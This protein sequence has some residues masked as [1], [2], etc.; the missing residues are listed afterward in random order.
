MLATAVIALAGSGDREP[1]A[2]MCEC[3]HW[4]RHHSVGKHNGCG[5]C[6]C[7]GFA[8]ARPDTTNQ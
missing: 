1:Q 4:T 7:K 3:G 2:D 6:G 5:H 8:A